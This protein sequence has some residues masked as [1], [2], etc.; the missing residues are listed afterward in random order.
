M[1]TDLVPGHRVADKVNNTLFLP[2][3]SAQVGCTRLTTP[4]FV[5]A[6]VYSTFCW[7]EPLLLLVP[8]SSLQV[9]CFTFCWCEPLFLLASISSLLVPCFT[10]CWREPLLL[11]VCVS[12]FASE[13]S[14]HLGNLQ[15]R[16]LILSS[17]FFVLCGQ[18]SVQ[19][20]GGRKCVLPSH[21]GRKREIGL[22]FL[23]R[24]TKNQKT[25]FW[26]TRRCQS[27]GGQG[28]RTRSADNVNI[29]LSLTL[30]LPC[31]GCRSLGELIIFRP[32]YIYIYIYN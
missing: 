27:I 8:V 13:Q 21:G 6:G 19:G 7:C 18:G 12:S 17:V 9:P 22:A 31:L 28:Q 2:P 11:L 4:C 25:A 30:S 32:P 10:F 26:Q 3:C 20:P 23:L 14:L 15:A 1:Y 16:F 5:F 29:T 24:G